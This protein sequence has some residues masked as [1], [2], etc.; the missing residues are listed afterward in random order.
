MLQ[1][2]FQTCVLSG[3]VTSKENIKT[4]NFKVKVKKCTYQTR[5][6]K[7]LLTM[8]L[9]QT[10][11]NAK[12]GNFCK[13]SLLW[14][15]QTRPTTRQQFYLNKVKQLLPKIA[16]SWNLSQVVNDVKFWLLSVQCKR[17]SSSQF[18]LR[19]SDKSI[20]I[21]KCNKK[22]KRKNSTKVVIFWK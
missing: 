4:K 21:F 14:L 19:H 6:Y 11:S 8:G 13:W 20:G 15:A 17:T 18:C 2:L 5:G 3:T 1:I 7:N 22:K 10:W 12:I 16:T 9:H